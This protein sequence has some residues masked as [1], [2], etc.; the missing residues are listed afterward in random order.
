VRVAELRGD[1]PAHVADVLEVEV[2]TDLVVLEGDQRKRKTR[3]AVEP[4]L[5]RD[6]EGVLRGALEAL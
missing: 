4:E 2:D 1:V 3:V 6:V 5:E